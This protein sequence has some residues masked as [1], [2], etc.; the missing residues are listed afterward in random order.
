MADQEFKIL[1]TG[2]ASGAVQATQQTSSAV[3]KIKVDISDL[4]DATKKSLNLLPE[5]AEA[6]KKLGSAVAETSEKMESGGREVRR[7]GNELGKMIGVSDLGATTMG[8]MGLAVFAVGAALEFLHSTYEQVQ[9]SIKGPIDISVHDDVGKIEAAAKVWDQYAEARRKAGEA[10]NSPESAAGRENKALEEKLKLL[11][12]FLKAEEEEALAALATHKDQMSPQ[13]YSAAES[14][15]KGTFGERSTLADQDAQR[16]KI[17][18]MEAEAAALDKKSKEDKAKGEAMSTGNADAQGAAKSNAEKAKASLDEIDTRIELIKRYQTGYIQGG[19][20]P[21]YMGSFGQIQKAGDIKDFYT[22]YGISSPKDALDIENRRK[23]E[24]QAAIALGGRA[25]DQ[26]ESRSKEKGELLSR[27]DTEASQADAIRQAVK[28]ALTEFAA[29][30]QTA[31]ATQALA[32]AATALGQEH[33]A[34][35]NNTAQGMADA[36]AARQAALSAVAALTAALRNTTDTHSKAYAA[37]LQALADLRAEDEKLAA[38]IAQTQ[39]NT[40]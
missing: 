21:E 20:V 2:D 8:K 36:A 11:H 39:F 37:I 40:H 13:A 38:K 17:A 14:R 6:T 33:A 26:F 1:I 5:Q 9:D 35:G 4:S 18:T 24:A 30:Q 22:R 25:T 28:D 7:L 27:A 31:Q 29:E 3:N 32:G 10:A 16:A 23:T 15:I 34:E 19:D 12:E